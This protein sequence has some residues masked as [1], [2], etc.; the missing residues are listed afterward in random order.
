M[1]R[2]QAGAVKH[3]LCHAPP[4]DPSLPAAPQITSAFRLERM[5]DIQEPEGA[6]ESGRGAVVEVQLADG[7]WHRGRL[8]ERVAGTE[9]PRW[10]V[11]F[12]TG[13]LRDDI[14]IGDPAAPVRFDASAYGARV[15]VRVAGGWCGGR[16]VDLVKE[17]NVWGVAFDDGD[18]AEDL[19][20]ED[21]NVRYVF[22]GPESGRAGKRGREEDMEDGSGGNASRKKETEDQDC[23]ECDTCG[24]AFSESR[25]LARHMMIHSGERPHVCETCGK[26]FSQAGNLATHMRTHSGE[27][28]HAC[29]TCGKAFSTSRDL[30]LHMRTHSGE[31]PHVCETCGKAFSRS[32]DLARH[33]RTHSGERPHACDTCGKAFSTSSD[34]ASHMLTHSGKRPHVCETCGK[35]FTQSSHLARHMR[36]HTVS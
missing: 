7:L 24:K 35:G 29:E 6:A 15:E 33:M 32:S 16:L 3:G 18:W 5:T 25:N 8:V 9:S 17:S 2:E 36:T 4:T 20:L 26:G 23:F 28:P 14:H 10:K 21:P 11:Q 31:R 1:D 19:R 12:D 34:L 13:L 27:R 30:T 22:A